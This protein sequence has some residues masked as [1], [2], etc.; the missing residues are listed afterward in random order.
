[1]C[2]RLQMYSLILGCVF[3]FLF[4]GCASQGSAVVATVAGDKITLAEFDTMYAKSNSAKDTSQKAVADDREKYLDL[5]VKFRLKVKDAYAHGYQNAPDVQAELQDY[6]KSL[7]VSMLM[8]QK[9]NE[10]AIRRM[11]DRKLYEVRSSHILLRMSQNPAPAETLATYM[12]A[13]KIIDSLK[14]GRPF[15][16]LALNNSQDP[17]VVSNKG[18]LYYSVAGRMVPEF[19]DAIFSVPS[20]TLIPYPSARNLATTLL[21]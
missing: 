16:V 12:K 5:Y 15:E 9:I 10:P 18:D 19:E 21:K 3:G 17:S 1:M 4:V 20:G 6:K 8:E 7:A 13:M 14:A 11:Y 2:Y